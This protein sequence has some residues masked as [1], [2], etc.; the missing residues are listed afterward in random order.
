MRARRVCSLYPVTA[1]PSAYGFIQDLEPVDI[2]IR[3]VEPLG[4]TA[5]TAGVEHI[6]PWPE[7]VESAADGEEVCCGDS[8]FT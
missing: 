5:H 3:R 7:G 1:G 6:A 4:A 8:L 2:R